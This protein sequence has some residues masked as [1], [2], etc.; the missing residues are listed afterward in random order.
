MKI[1]GLQL[2]KNKEQKT[3]DTGNMMFSTPLMDIGRGNLS[4]P[5]VN[6]NY[7]TN[8]Y[9]L[10]GNDNLYPQILIQLY[11]QSAIHGACIDFI[12]NSVIGGG[13]TWDTFDTFTA[14]EIIEIKT[15][16][17]KTR[18]K[19]M[20]KSITKDWT[21]HRRVVIEVITKD[22]KVVNIKRL[23]PSKVRNNK[24]KSIFVY[25]DDWSMGLVNTKEYK[26]YYIGCPDGSH[27]LYFEEEVPGQDIYPIPSYN[28]ILNWAF[29]DSEQSFFHK[30]NLQNGI[31][32]SL[33]IRRPKNFSSLEE[34]KKFKEEISL[35]TGA[36]N[37]GKVMVLTGN[38]FDDTPQIESISSNNNDNMFLETSREIKE[39]ICI[40]H[41]INPS[42]M[43]VKVSGQ[44]GN[45]TEIKDS[46]LIFEKNVVKPERE[47]LEYILNE[48]VEVY[49]LKTTLTIN[50]YQIID[51][52]ITEIVE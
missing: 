8:N 39:N 18:F 36:S 24:D 46:Y 41:K 15:F 35:K 31:F 1:L 12:S 19:Q 50:N 44:L 27:I 33:A 20:V 16:E 34:I 52:E 4:L 17:K 22:K 32:P 37:A 25:S 28:S 14:R 45:T 42:I 11:L 23:D 9:V 49:G 7:T 48:I 10:F 51:G 21:I 13:Y 26:K 3:T 5:Y 47:E 29:L 38:G 6:S 2:T 40:A 30:S 43:G